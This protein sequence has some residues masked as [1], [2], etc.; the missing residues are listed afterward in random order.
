MQPPTQVFEPWH[1]FYM[2]LGTASATMIGLLF[3][4]ASIS[5]GIFARSRRG[6]QR[7]FLSASVVHFGS[8]LGMCLLVL[9]PFRGW[10]DFGGLV[11]VGG[12][13]GL[14]YSGLTWADAVRDG[15]AR[16]IDLEDRSWYALGPVIGY[17]IEVASGAALMLRFRFG[18]P[19]LAVAMGT[20]LLVSIHNAW[21]ITIWTVT[22]DKD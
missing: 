18:C 16:K 7:M 13:F 20:L 8:V 12:L 11:V 6:A 2:L 15:L 14:A 19:A 21:D 3:V 4:A 10:S 17:L 1:D 9:A 22:R 5:S